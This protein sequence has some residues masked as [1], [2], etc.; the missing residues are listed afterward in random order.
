MNIRKLLYLNLVHKH[1]GWFDN[2]DNAPGILTSTLASDAQVINGVCTEGLGSQLEASF[3]TLAGLIIGFIY[4]WQIFVVCLVC[5]S[6][7]ICASNM[8]IQF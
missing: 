6:F 2:K 7:M 1:I 4:C 8:N 3:A 5:V